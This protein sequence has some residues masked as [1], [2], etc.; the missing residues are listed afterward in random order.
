M[1]REKD[2]NEEKEDDDNKQGRRC[3]SRLK[4]SESRPVESDQ[5]VANVLGDEGRSG[6][7]D[8]E[9]GKNAGRRKWGQDNVHHPSGPYCGQWGPGDQ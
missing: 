6:A 2:A 7:C 3:E 5:D 9:K 1:I 4:T 8:S